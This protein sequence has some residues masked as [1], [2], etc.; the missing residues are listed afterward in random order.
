VFGD[1]VD[2]YTMTESVRDEITVRIV[3]EG[4]TAKV[5]LNNSKLNEIEKYY[6]DCVAEGASEYQVDESKRTSANMNAILGD[7]DRLRAIAEDFVHHYEKR[8]E[9]GS[10]VIGKALFVC[11]SRFIAYDLYKQ[12]INIRPQW[13]EV[14]I[15]E[16]GVILSD[17]E[18][19][20]IKP[21]ERVKMI[22]TRGQDDPLEFYN[23]LGTKEYRKELDRQFKST[24]SS[25]LYRE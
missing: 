2:A 17:R 11:S 18:K 22:M 12:I 25:R 6:E 10:T 24:A 4:R 19:K 13:A 7:P 15:C 16:E 14:L 23:L 9:E 21:M 3:Y 20:E 8:V 1:V 5:L